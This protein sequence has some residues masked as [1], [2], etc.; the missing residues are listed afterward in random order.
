MTAKRSPRKL[1][2]ALAQTLQRADIGFNLARI[3][4]AVEASA[5]SGAELVCFA[6]CALTGYGPIHYDAPDA[7]DAEAVRDGVARVQALARRHRTSVVLGAHLPA[8]EG[9]W[10]NSL[11]YMDA[12]GRTRAR[13][14]KIHLYDADADY[15]RPGAAPPK[16]HT[17]AGL[18]AGL[19]ICFDLRFAELSRDL[20]LGGA[21]A[22]VIPSYIHGA[23]TMWKGPVIEGALR[24]RASDNGRYVLFVN[25]AGRTQNVPSMAID[26]DGRL[27]AKARKFANRVVTVA[28]D[29]GA[30]SNRFL[31]CRRPELYT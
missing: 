11:L 8:P 18:K 12:G 10:T 25:A 15:Y 31:A 6:E 23:T 2:V 29:P 22:F 24:C 1:T 14:D 17:L 9:G 19:Q 27:V 28:I 4:E 30:V 21:E 7:F 5:A 3:A 16:V 20:A 13:Y 26:P